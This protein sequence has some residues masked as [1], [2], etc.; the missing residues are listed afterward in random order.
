MENTVG[1]FAWKEWKRPYIVLAFRTI[2]DEARMAWFEVHANRQA[3]RALV[4]CHIA[5]H[6]PLFPSR[7]ALTTLPRTVGSSIRIPPL[8]FYF[9]SKTRFRNRDPL[10][11]AGR[12][13]PV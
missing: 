3:S 5:F 11:T 6:V 1:I 10:P 12:G 4:S 13:F 2:E 7:L 9:T 8:S